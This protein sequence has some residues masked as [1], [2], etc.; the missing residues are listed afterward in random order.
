VCEDFLFP[1]TVIDKKKLMPKKK[2]KS[3]IVKKKRKKNKTKLTTRFLFL[4]HLFNI[5]SFIFFS[6]QIKLILAVFFLLLIMSSVNY[7]NEGIPSND[8]TTNPSGTIIQHPYLNPN[9]YA[10][11]AAVVSS[12][13]SSSTVGQYH[14]YYGHP[15]PPQQLLHVQ[16]TA[17]FYPPI[18]ALNHHQH[19]AD[20]SNSSP[21]VASSSSSIE[22]SRKTT[23]R[24][25]NPTGSEKI[26]GTT[27]PTKV[28]TKRKM[29]CNIFKKS[30][31][32]EIFLL[33]HG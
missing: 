23:N 8:E 4:F 14:P 27:V 17:G 6:F 21:S 19:H 20:F 26:P 13:S 12:A 32:I 22:S 30:H 31:F 18:P 16:Q 3:L 33:A 1:K 2:K 29:V 10:A 25:R 7:G 5:H 9:T 15:L 24:K 28:N 11:A